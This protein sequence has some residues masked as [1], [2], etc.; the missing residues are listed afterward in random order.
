[1]W[2]K[3][4]MPAACILAAVWWSLFYP[5]LC[6]TEETCEA[7]RDVDAEEAD[8]QRV[9]GQ[10]W[11]TD[12]ISGILRADD[13]EIVVSSRFLEWCEAKLSDKKE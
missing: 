9:D 4:R 13:G 6:F 11:E 2:K 5:E 1:M 10:N 8:E 3:G 7:V 12:G